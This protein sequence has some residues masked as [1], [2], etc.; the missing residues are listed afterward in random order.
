V[1]VGLN[2][3]PLGIVAFLWFLAVIRRRLGEREDRFF[4]T[5]F[6][7]SGLAFAILTIAAAV[8]AAIPTL[9]V[10]FGSDPVPD[11]RSVALAHALWFGLWGVG[12]SRMVGVFIAGTSTVGLRFGA[13]PRWLST[14]G[15]VLGA[16]LGLTGAFVGPLDF[17]FPV[18]LV[19][20]SGTLLLVGRRRDRLVDDASPAR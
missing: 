16:V 6:F 11:P 9:M 7:G 5:V 15:V 10:R 14:F 4:A 17:L 3:A 8:A 19:V 13:F 20:V 18:W 1:L 12:G 2:L